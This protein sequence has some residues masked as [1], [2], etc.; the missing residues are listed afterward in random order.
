MNAA[1]T[2][3]TRTIRPGFPAVE[4][5]DLVA[6]EDPLEIRIASRC[7]GEPITRTVALT[8]RTPGDDLE[9]AVGYLFAEGIVRDVSDIV[10]LRIFATTAGQHV[11]RV[12]VRS[13]LD[14]DW[15]RLERR[16]AVSSA[17]GACG[18][19]SAEAFASLRRVTHDESQ[20]PVDAPVLQAMPAVLLRRQAAF[21]ATG[22]MHAAA[23]FSPAGTLLSLR[24]DVGR[25]NA[26]DKLVG[27]AFLAHALPLSSRVL[28]LSGRVGFELVQKA[29]MAGIAIV[30]AV[31]APSSMAVEGARA[32]GVTLVGFV[33]DGRCNVYTHPTRIRM[34]EG[35]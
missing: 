16:G 33:R 6:V 2:W 9:L 3:P 4:A 10:S 25:H 26:L 20:P 7:D 28:L 34:G 29:A 19:A 11:A 30:A 27:A 5:E 15:R 17:C 12:E 32:A 13:G 24:E 18:R 8:L 35:A 31:G 23:L 22:G 1:I 14:I 21:A